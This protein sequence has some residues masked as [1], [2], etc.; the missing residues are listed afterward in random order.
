MRPLLRLPRGPVL[1]YAWSVTFVVG[2][3][4]VLRPIRRSGGCGCVR[5][6]TLFSP[7]HTLH[8]RSCRNCYHYDEIFGRD[9][10]AEQH[11]EEAG[12]H[13]D[14]AGD[15]GT[16]TIR[17]YLVD[18]GHVVGITMSLMEIDKADHR[19]HVAFNRF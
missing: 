19:L 9:H 2:L 15:Q 1:R 11:L 12:F 4:R 14:L 7:E 8:K 16:H 13:S 5:S 6:R 17:R 3:C 18:T 10:D